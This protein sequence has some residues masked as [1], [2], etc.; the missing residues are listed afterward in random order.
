MTRD[1]LSQIISIH[2]L[3]EEG[4]AD[5]DVFWVCAGISIHALREKGDG[6]TKRFARYAERFLSTPSARRATQ[7]HA[8]RPGGGGISIHAL[9]EE[10]D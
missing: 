6:Q 7:G 5:R 2:A 9:R 3:R 4:D 1:A 8:H 10:G